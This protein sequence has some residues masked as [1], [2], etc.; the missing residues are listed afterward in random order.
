[1]EFI[2]CHHVPRA[3]RRRHS[4]P[5]KTAGKVEVPGSPLKSPTRFI[6]NASISALFLTPV[7]C[8][9]LECLNTSAD[10]HL[11]VIAL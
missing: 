6:D 5:A 4:E 9:I 11:H 3:L 10:I 2:R 7:R 8:S 1:M